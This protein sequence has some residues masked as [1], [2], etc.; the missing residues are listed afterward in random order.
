[1]ILSIRRQIE[2]ELIR[3]GIY[4][5]LQIRSGAC[6]AADLAAGPAED[7]SLRWIITT[8]QPATVFDWM[9]FDFVDE[10]LLMD[11]MTVPAIKQVPFLDSHSRRSVDDILGSVADF[12]NLRISGYEAISGAVN[13]AADEKSQRTLQKALDGHLTDGS[14][15]YAVTR[16]VWIPADETAIVRGRQFD[17]PLKVSYEWSLR[18]F[19]GTPIGADTLAKVRSFMRMAGPEL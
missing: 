18:E 8:E 10:V 12:Q 6:R 17:G 7:G 4:P 2:N 16:S 15:G 3:A 14:A 9:R 13:F 1:M 11:G 19:S 5:G